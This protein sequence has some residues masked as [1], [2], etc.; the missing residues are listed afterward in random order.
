MDIAAAWTPLC[1]EF[2]YLR[3]LENKA[4]TIAQIPVGELL[5][6]DAWEGKYALVTYQGAQG[7]VTANYI[8]PA[9]S[10]Y[11]SSRLQTV[12]LSESYSHAQMV[13]D[14]QT[15]QDKYPE[16]V[17]ISS[18]GQSAEGRDIPV[19]RIGSSNAK[20]HVLLQG[21]MHGREHFTACLLM[22]ICDIS[23]SRNLFAN[24]DVCYHFIPMTNPDGVFIS[25]SQ[26][27]SDG[28]AEIYQSDI[29]NGHTDK[30]QSAYAQMWK[31]NAL[32]VDMNRN[33]PSGWEVSLEREDPSSERFRGD[34]PLCAPESIALADYTKAY[35]FSATLSFHSH[36]SVLYYRYGTKE[37]VNTLSYRL[38]LA[39]SE[40]TGYTPVGGSDG[41]SG[42]GYKDW[43]MDA[44]DIPSITVEIGSSQTPLARRDLYNTFARFENFIPAI[45][46]WLA[47]NY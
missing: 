47:E 27:L 39:V 15:L 18:I 37:P 40:I 13:A 23:L 22:A 21:A 33:F 41:T 11:F 12:A 32:G 43:A 36:G 4:Q 44:L 16:L 26:A 45:E 5:K 29:A 28:Q 25:Q 1:E 34:S 3:S 31:A 46:Q 10:A 24:S 17:A 35:D 2:I 20:Y 38:A 9:D 7:Y 30:S 6:L 14:L 8:Q 19:M 42:A